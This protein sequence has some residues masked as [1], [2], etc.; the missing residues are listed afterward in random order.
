MSLPPPPLDT[1]SV[2]FG[3]PPPPPERIRPS[4]CYRPC[5]FCPPNNGFGWSCPIPVPSVGSDGPLYPLDGPTPP[6]HF[7]CASC[8]R[9]AASEAPSTTSC[10]IC[11]AHY[12][13]APGGHSYYGNGEGGVCSPQT[14]TN[15]KPG[16]GLWGRS[17]LDLCD[18]IMDGQSDE[19]M[20]ACVLGHAQGRCRSPAFA[21]LPPLA[22]ET[23]RRSSLSLPVRRSG[24]LLMLNGRS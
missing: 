3:A 13:G 19:M 12:C 18:S 16:E 11:E 15:S 20:N 9:L 10:S 8:T 2:Q 21:D 14:F 6:G 23:T 22:S 7:Q 5:R 4:E 1:P 24:L 17:A